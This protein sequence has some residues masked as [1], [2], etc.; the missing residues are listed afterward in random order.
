MEKR[1]T[2]DVNNKKIA[3]VCAGIANYFDLD[4]TLVRVIW[5]LLVCAAGTG[6]LAYLIA[7]AVMPEA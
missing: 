4:P 2:R 5:I 1:L 3:G 6:V 7:W